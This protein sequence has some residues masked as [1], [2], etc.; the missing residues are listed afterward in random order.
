MEPFDETRGTENVAHAW[1]DGSAAGGH[2]SN[3]DTV[4]NYTGPRPG[5]P[6]NHMLDESAKY[7]G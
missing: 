6:A 7:P 1:Y 4:L 2:P 3:G 5:D